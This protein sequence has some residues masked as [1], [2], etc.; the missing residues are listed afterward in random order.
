MKLR[1]LIVG[2]VVLF[3]LVVVFYWSEHRKRTDE[4]AARPADAPAIL[5]LDESAIT[6]IEIKKRETA[7]LVLAKNNAGSWQILEPKS[8]NADQSA[9]SGMLST[10]SALNS[11]RLVDEKASDLKQYG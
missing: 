3:A 2:L 6:K 10:L 7:P 9:V 4:N 11:E 1:G 8:L 5:K